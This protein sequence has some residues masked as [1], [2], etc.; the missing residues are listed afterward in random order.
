MERYYQLSKYHAIDSKARLRYGKEF[1]KMMIP[2]EPIADEDLS[3]GIIDNN[4]LNPRRLLLAPK[5]RNT[6]LVT[7]PETG[8]T[9]KVDKPGKSAS[10]CLTPNDCGPDLVK[11]MVRDDLSGTPDRRDH[12]HIATIGKIKAAGWT[13]F[14]APLQLDKK[15]LHVRMVAERTINSGDDPTEEDAIR[16]AQAFLK[17]L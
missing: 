15:I 17:A 8:D 16:L 9:C 10:I 3:L 1:E 7:I 14:W 6:I 5:D 12:I 4:K 13:P 11:R 2:C